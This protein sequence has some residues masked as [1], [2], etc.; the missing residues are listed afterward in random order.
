[1]LLGPVSSPVWFPRV[2]LL[3]LPPTYEHDRFLIQP[4]DLP[5]GQTESGKSTLDILAQAVPPS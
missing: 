1:M 3:L 5:K 4:A 2:K